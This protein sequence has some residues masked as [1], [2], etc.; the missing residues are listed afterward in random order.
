[1]NCKSCG[2]PMN[3][4]EI[5]SARKKDGYPNGLCEDCRKKWKRRQNLKRR[6]NIT[7]EEYDQLFVYQ[8][9]KCQICNDDLTDKRAVVDHCHD[10]G[11][12]RG[13]L[14]YPCNT[15][16]GFLKDDVRIALRLIDY[17]YKTEK[18]NGK[19]K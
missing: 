6:Y 2:T 4:D 14:C 7:P 19:L 5:T 18:E 3:A 13:I 1:M 15:A 10:T 11:T 16:I 12:V 17:L 8:G 9:K